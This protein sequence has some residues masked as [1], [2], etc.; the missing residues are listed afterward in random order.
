M[1]LS[2]Q[3]G[4]VGQR[5]RQAAAPGLFHAGGDCVPLQGAEGT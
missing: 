2:V 4:A 5:R 3:G 1:A